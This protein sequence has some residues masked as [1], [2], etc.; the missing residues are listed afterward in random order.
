MTGASSSGPSGLSTAIALA[1]IGSA[2]NNI[3]KV[4]QKQAT[5]D[6]PQMSMDPKVLLLY[7]SSHLWRLG[8][9]ADVGGALITLIALSM[10]PVSVI[11]P[12]G[13]C[14]MAILALFSHF[15][16]KEILRTIERI[17]VAMA[18]IGTIGVGL[19][20]SQSKSIMPNAAM[21][22][23]LLAVMAFTFAVLEGSLRHASRASSGSK[24]QVLADTGL[25]EAIAAGRRPIMHRIEVVAGLQ[26][27]MLFGLSA[28]SA[29]TGML[30][31]ELLERPVLAALGVACSI[32]FSSAGIFCQN[33]GMKEGR[34]VVVCTYAVIGTIVSGVVIGL[35]ALNEGIPSDSIG[36]WAC[37]LLCILAGI[38]LLM[39]RAPGST[40][41]VAKE[42]KEVV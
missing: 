4:L 14:G 38:G 22:C 7:T 41:K 2:S 21:G 19:T 29:R 27:G 17:G 5:T 32:A 15:Y 31:S 26:G 35:L 39:R 30:L 11:Q 40:T 10:A 36:G 13:G 1:V 25:G 28:A 18:V 8:L 12:V 20:A 24:L 34:A 3:G 9:L 23:F 16:L 6:L 33:R 37:S 42:L